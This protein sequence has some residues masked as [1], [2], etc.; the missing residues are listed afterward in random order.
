[1]KK[2]FIISVLFFGCQKQDIKPTTTNKVI[3]HYV[4]S[5][6]ADGMLLPQCF[7]NGKSVDPQQG[8][9]VQTGDSVRI[10]SHQ[11]GYTNTATMQTGYF[12]QTTSI[13]INGVTKSNKSCNCN[14]LNNKYN[15]N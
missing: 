5:F 2:L 6:K 3:N 1:M 7:I 13:L 9:D 15:V 12:H 8:Y 10:T 4:V 14:T 11:S